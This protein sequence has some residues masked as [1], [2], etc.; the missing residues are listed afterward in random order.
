MLLWGI[1]VKFIESQS[2]TAHE[3]RWRDSWGGEGNYIWSKMGGGG[4]YVWNPLVNITV[5]FSKKQKCNM[6]VFSRHYCWIRKNIHLRRLASSGCHLITKEDHPTQACTKA[7]PAAG[8]DSGVFEGLHCIIYGHYCWGV[9]VLK[10]RDGLGNGEWKLN[11]GNGVCQPPEK[12][13][14][15]DH[16]GKVYAGM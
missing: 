8:A 16:L 6:N 9:I 11:L 15:S 5:C 3:S 7:L 4:E 12:S 14:S 1:Q 10:E 13:F 2:T